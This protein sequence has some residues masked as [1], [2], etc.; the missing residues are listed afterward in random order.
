MKSSSSS[1]SVDR[2]H[3]SVYALV[4]CQAL[5]I[6]WSPDFNMFEMIWLYQSRLWEGFWTYGVQTKVLDGISSG[7][8]IHSNTAT[9]LSPVYWPS[10]IQFLAEEL[11]RTLCPKTSRQGLFQSQTRVITTDVHVWA[12]VKV[13]AQNLQ[14]MKDYGQRGDQNTASHTVSSYF[15]GL[16]A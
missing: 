10:G 13:D 2:K 3:C 5:N 7:H 9:Q 16:N 15:R 6:L 12:Q 4:T 11:S 1:S 8:Q 14:L